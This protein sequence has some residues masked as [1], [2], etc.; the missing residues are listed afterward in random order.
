MSAIKLKTVNL[1]NGETLGYREREGGSEVVLLIHGNMT[2]SKHWDLVL[3]NMDEKYKL[4]A[5]DM[6]GFG[7]SSYN[8]P[9]R[10][11]KDFANDIKL[12]VDELQLKY[13]S[14]F[15]WSTGG[16]VGMQFVA[17]NPGYCKKL[18]LLASAST[19]GYPLFGM[20]E[21]GQPDL[22]KRIATLEEV[23]ED[24]QRT[25]PIQNAYDMKN[26]QFLKTLWDMLIYRKHQP[27]D[28]RYDEYLDDMLTQRNLA[29]VYQALNTF[30]ISE[31]H[32]GLTEGSG[33]VSNI[34]IPALVLRGDEDLVVTDQMT[35]EI[36]ADLSNNAT[37]IELAGCGHSPLVDDLEKLLRIVSEFIELPEDNNGINRLK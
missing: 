34:S 22:T 19:R 7:I 11:I 2:S 28:E 29:E 33:L 5:V 10:S 26:K 24:K 8:E 27:N 18:I 17:E 20:N 6:R 25:I 30:N 14:I 32:N 35:R 36:L 16:A 4:Y 15:G 37:Y 13:F 23:K 12:F 9:I 1:L 31:V 21:Q 3:E